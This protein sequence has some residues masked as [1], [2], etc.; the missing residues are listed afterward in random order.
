MWTDDVNRA[1]K[2]PD[3]W[4]VNREDLGTRLSCFDSEYRMVEHFTRFTTKKE[5]Q[6]QHKGNLTD[7][8]CYL[9]NICSTEQPFI[10]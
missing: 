9:E 2:W 4:T 10:S 5:K 6:E 3:Y 1:A 8:I 7:D